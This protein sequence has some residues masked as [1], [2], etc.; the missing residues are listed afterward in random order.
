MRLVAHIARGSARMLRRNDLRKLFR[1]G[2]IR[3]VTTDAK[4]GCFQF[5]RLD[6]ARVFRMLCQRSM[7]RLAVDSRMLSFLL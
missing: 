7:A 2:D 6:R 3:L 1:F 5:R 4:H